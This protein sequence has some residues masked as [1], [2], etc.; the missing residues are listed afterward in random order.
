MRFLESYHVVEVWT[1]VPL[2]PQSTP[3]S[4]LK[5][6]ML[7][8]EEGYLLFWAEAGG[9]TDFLAEI[10]YKAFLH[11]QIYAIA[12]LPVCDSRCSW[13]VDCRSGQAIAFDVW[14]SDVRPTW[15]GGEREKNSTS[16]A[17]LWGP[18]TVE[19]RCVGNP[20]VQNV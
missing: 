7:Y 11:L 10:C 12:P 14:R 6:I 4:C 16:F 15:E 18:T 20:I 2:E 19:V 8:E 5:Y 9:F 13:L 17:N 1:P 3:Q